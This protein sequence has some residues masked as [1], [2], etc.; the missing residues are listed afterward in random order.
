MVKF[1]L[2][3]QTRM[4]FRKC[5]ENVIV[6]PVFEFVK[7]KLVLQILGKYQSC[8][9][10][11]W[12]RIC[13][14]YIYIYIWICVYIWM[15]IYIWIY[16]YIPAHTHSRLLAWHPL[17]A[18]LEKTTIAYIRIRYWH[19]SAVGGE[20]DWGHSPETPRTSRQHGGLNTAPMRHDTERFG[21]CY[22]CCT[23]VAAGV[24]R[25]SAHPAA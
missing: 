8:S 9:C 12:H 19:L 21:L 15:R 25:G 5:D 10:N 7:K 4:L 18:W 24:P 16:I 22:D 6:I 14:Y 13:V 1:K 3:F 11:Y 2:A 17:C 20:L 23:F